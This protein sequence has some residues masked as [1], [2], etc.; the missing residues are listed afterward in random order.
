[1]W[2]VRRKRIGFGSAEAFLRKQRTECERA[3]TVAGTCKELA[4]GGED[5]RGR[6]EEIGD[7]HLLLGESWEVDFEGLILDD[8]IWLAIWNVFPSWR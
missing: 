2:F 8:A 1:V 5:G 4:A 7:A 6:S 3:E